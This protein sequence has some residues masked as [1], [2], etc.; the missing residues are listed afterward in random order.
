[1]VT[2]MGMGLGFVSDGLH[3]DGSTSVFFSS[4][5]SCTYVLKAYYWCQN[6]KLLKFRDMHLQY[7]WNV[8]PPNIGAF[9][10]W[11]TVCVCACVYCSFE[12]LSATIFQVDSSEK[13]TLNK[14]NYCWVLTFAECGYIWNYI[15]LHHHCQH[16]CCSGLGYR[17]NY[18]PVKIYFF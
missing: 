4:Y 7:M 14:N 16:R 15:Q 6:L 3:K 18:P 9:C 12:A 5:I 8:G 10:Q 17:I 13:K 1:M 2:V 11:P